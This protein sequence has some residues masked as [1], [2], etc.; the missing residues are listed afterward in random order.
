MVRQDKNQDGKS[1]LQAFCDG[2]GASRF[3]SR[4]VVCRR[5]NNGQFAA[6]MHG[7]HTLGDSKSQLQPGLS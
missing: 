2:T 6:A 1:L 4:A 7:L 3:R 5:K